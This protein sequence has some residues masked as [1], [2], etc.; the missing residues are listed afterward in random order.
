MLWFDLDGVLRDLQVA[1][2]GH[3]APCWDY[4][5][6]G[7]G[8]VEIINQDRTLL[9]SAPPT[10][11]YPAIAQLSEIVI[12]THQQEGWKNLAE[13]W[14]RRYLPDYT[15]IIFVRKPEDK[16]NYLTFD[17]DILVDDYPFFKS[18]EKVAL[19]DYP[20]NQQCDCRIRI[21]TAGDM[22]ALIEYKG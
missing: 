21:K 5:P 6:D 11:Y 16:F 14:V 8:L 13:F 7:L 15:R 9:L 19:V 17:D 2:W 3:N 18:Y 20:Y 12:L 22:E 4:A 10:K 1:I